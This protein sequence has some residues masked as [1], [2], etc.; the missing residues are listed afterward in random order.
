ME[1]TRVHGILKNHCSETEI[2]TFSLDFTFEFLIVNLC[3]SVPIIITIHAMFS[4]T[5]KF[6][7]RP[8]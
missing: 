6:T 7:F 1:M 8:T 5:E 4:L 2:N 3:L